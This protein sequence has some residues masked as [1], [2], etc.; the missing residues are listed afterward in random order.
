MPDGPF[1]AIALPTSRSGEAELTREL[2]QQ[3]HTRLV[4]GG[5]LWTW[6]DNPHDHWLERQ[7]REYFTTVR[8]LVWA[9][10]VVYQAA[11]HGPPKKLRNFSACFPFR[12]AGRLLWL[13]TRPGVFAHR[14]VDAGARRLIEAMSIRAKMRILEIGCG[15]GAVSIA[16]AARCPTAQVTAIDSSPRAIQCVQQAA[17]HNQLSNITARV[18]STSNYH[19][20]GCFDLVLTN[21]P[22]YGRFQIAER[23]VQGAAEALVERGTLL[24]VTKHPT[25]YAENLEH[26]YGQWECRAVRGGYWIVTAHK[27]RTS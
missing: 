10:D 23:F 11:R 22:Y 17:L 18:F 2:I 8:R 19:A 15:S 14:R 6:V 1:D 5:V 16:A 25:W 12:D 26:W 21:P 20:L 4:E 3:A 27:M 13:Y 9:N 7:L 24:V